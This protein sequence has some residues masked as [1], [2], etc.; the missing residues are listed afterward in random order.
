[1]RRPPVHRRCPRGG[2]DQSQ[3]ARADFRRSVSRRSALSVAGHSHRGST[4]ALEVLVRY[5]WP[6]NV[7]ELHNVIE[8]AV[9]L[10]P[11]D[12][13]DVEHL[14]ETVRRSAETVLPMRER[15]TQ[16]SD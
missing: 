6:G 10:A 14:P 7:R 4:A 15:R 5:R 11:T 12:L 2:C 3:P 16:V 9:W 8:Q 1:Q 13:I